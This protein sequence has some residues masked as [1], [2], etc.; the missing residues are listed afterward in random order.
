M[1]ERQRW[2]RL[3]DKGIHSSKTLHALPVVSAI[4]RIPGNKCK[5]L[6]ARLKSHG[7]NI[8]QK[9][10]GVTR[11]ATRRLRVGSPSIAT[12]LKMGATKPKLIPK[13]QQRARLCRTSMLPN[14]VLVPKVFGTP[15]IS[16]IGKTRCL[17]RFRNSRTDDPQSSRRTRLFGR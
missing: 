10:L 3:R 9:K 14:G 12:G 13:G 1:I 8:H 16:F 15:G 6:K 5:N 17:R 4:C 11:S 7:Q 2:I